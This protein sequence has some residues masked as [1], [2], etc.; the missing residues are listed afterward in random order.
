MSRRRLRLGMVGGGYGANIGRIHRHAA[1]MDGLFELVCGAFD[2]DP[3]RSRAFGRE[4]LGLDPERC[5]GDVDELIAG[6]RARSD[7]VD[8]VAVVTPNH[9]H[10]PIARRLL[11]AGF[12]VLCEKPLTTRGEDARDLARLARERG[13]LLAVAYCYWGF[14]LVQE[15][16]ARILRGDLGRIRV[17]RALCPIQWMAAPIEREGHGA[18]AWRADP[19]RAGPGG[20]IADV[21]THAFHLARTVTGMVPAK[22]AADLVPLVEGRVLDDD[23]GVWLEY[24]DGAR[25]RL[26][27][28]QVA[29]GHSQGLAVE[30][31]GER[32]GLSWRLQDASRLYWTPLGDDTR[33]IEVGRPGL[34]EEA[35]AFVRTPHGHPEGYIDAFANLYRGA[36]ERIRHLAGGPEPGPVGRLLPVADPDGI[37]GVALVEAAVAASR[38]RA[39][40]DFAPFVEGTA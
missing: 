23:A 17:V 15:M 37:E 4:E 33:V 36:F 34:S 38:A 7:P 20:V 19:A 10:A 40:V 18:A 16:R 25:G 39:W 32:G 2:A 1:A 9:T 5:Y 31:F 13:L 30:V 11:E 14:S 27:L 28:S 8:L 35:R 26:W 12:H 22:L 21:G 24:P 29:V 3:D 6:E